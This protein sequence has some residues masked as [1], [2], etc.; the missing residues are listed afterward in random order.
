MLV[1]HIAEVPLDEPIQ[2]LS[3]FDFLEAQDVRVDLADRQ[4][5]RGELVV[6]FA[7]VDVLV[8]PRERGVVVVVEEVLD[9]VVREPD[10][11]GGLLGGVGDAESA[12]RLADRADPLDLR[13]GSVHRIGGRGLGAAGRAHAQ[14]RHTRGQHHNG[15]ADRQHLH[16][17]LSGNA[18]L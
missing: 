7:I 9:V 4:R 15:P 8:A 14:E 10:C 13:L 16:E 1:A 11:A 18:Q 17:G 12:E 6:R 3:R 5:R 2:G